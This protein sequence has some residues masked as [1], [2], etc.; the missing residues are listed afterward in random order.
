MGE[1]RTVIVTGGAGYLG[2]CAV[3]VLQQKGYRPVVIDNFSRSSIQ[4]VRGVEFYKVDLTN[5]LE[6]REAFSKIGSAYALIHF[7]AL[8]LVE[9]SVK[10][11]ELYLA[12][13]VGAAK[14]VAELCSEHRI[15]RV[16]HSSSCTVYGIPLSNPITESAALSPISPYG[17]SKLLAE[18]V[19]DAHSAQGKFRSVNLRYFNPVGAVGA[20]GE[21]H[22]PETH[23]IPRVVNALL[24]QQSV[25]LFGNDYPTQDGTCVRD[26]IHV[27]D[28]IDGHLLAL[29]WL[30]ASDEG[31]PRAIN[32]GSGNGNSVSEVIRAAESLLKVRANTVVLPKRSGDPPVL[33]A[34]TR[35]A[36]GL[37]GWMPVRDLSAMISDHLAFV[38]GRE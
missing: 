19:F 8:A 26:F 13:N 10:L 36:R 25:E 5:G 11:P 33:V 3:E 34:D 6:S 2:R 38:R 23:L 29:D 4:A 28:L 14:T 37:L 35:L 1:S 27:K 30:G 21:R 20:F 12:N 16:I 9:E 22:E 32:L 15:S 31:S 24:R 18:R 7:A 17:Q